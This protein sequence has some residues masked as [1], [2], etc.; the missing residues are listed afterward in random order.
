MTAEVT[1][2][3]KTA[4]L[5]LLLIAASTL[6]EREL[7]AVRTSAPPQIDGRLTDIVWEAAK[8]SSSFIYRG[9]GLPWP[10]G[11]QT[12]VRVLYDDEALYFALACY[13][14]QP[15]AIVSDMLRHDDPLWLDDSISILLDTFD[16][17]RSGYWFIVNAQGSRYDAVFSQDGTYIDEEWDGNWRAAARVEE[18]R[19]VAEIAIP[20]RA[21]HY[22]D[23][24]D[25]LGI[26]FW[27]NEI[28]ND[29]SSVWANYAGT[30]FQAA[31]FGR[32]GG[33]D[34]LDTPVT[35][36]ITPYLTAERRWNDVEEGILY[37]DP[38]LYEEGVWDDFNG[39]VDLDFRPFGA[40][41]LAATWN[42]DFAHIESDL[43][44]INL[45]RDELYLNEKRPFFREGKSLFELPL[46]L[47]YSRRIA[48]IDYAG[49]LY[50]KL[51]G[52]RYYVT[53]VEGRVFDK[54]EYTTYRGDYW[55]EALRANVA[56]L[57]LT[58]DIFDTSTVGLTVVNKYQRERFEV[59]YGPF[60][61]TEFN[62]VED[63]FN[64]TILGADFSM[65]TDYDL[66]AVGQFAYQINEK[67][68]VEDFAW[69]LD[70]EWEDPNWTLGFSA[71]QVRPNFDAEM[72]YLPYSDLDTLGG[73]VYGEYLWSIWNDWLET[74][75]LGG[76]YYHYQ[77]N[78]GGPL[79]YQGWGGYGGADL[80]A[81]L[82]LS[83][84]YW[85]A[86][87]TEEYYEDER[88]S[89]ENLFYS[90]TLGYGLDRWSNASFS[91]IG[92]R[93]YGYDL[94]YW[95]LAAALAP[96]SGLTLEG[97]VEYERL[98]GEDEYYSMAGDH[99]FVSAGL[100]AKFTDTLWLR[101]FGQ[102]NT[103]R[104]QEEANALLAW[105]YL[106]GSYVYLAYNLLTPS[107]RELAEHILFLKVSFSLDI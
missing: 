61:P 100:S 8:P 52:L 57:R 17:G 105:N 40:M 18:D 69:Y 4:L 81:G 7:E 97:T 102:R 71:Q 98:I 44:E 51:G 99:W 95:E 67:N 62:L 79:A 77:E 64:D 6:A 91:Y 21:I 36:N 74:T 56:A 59:E 1:V 72:G 9:I 37:N 85:Q 86:Y 60:G 32:L 16:D 54:A 2:R 75:Y 24:A 14:S 23:P 58:H 13:E 45:S 83:G 89:F 15:E 87:E 5:L 76:Y 73:E 27:R 34:D 103:L 65:A 78:D 30:L 26:E 12:V 22:V 11:E 43:N 93:Y 82:S 104:G 46:Q 94:H 31:G 55:K 49:K 39:G 19:W 88:W 84:S 53:D 66:L 3:A 10:A 42:P 38:T 63:T 48:E 25:G 33:I 28:P 68:E 107:T 35:L 20:W 41:S 50:G 96:F 47:F 106:P 90:G 80:A 92:G 29:E 70:G 101:L